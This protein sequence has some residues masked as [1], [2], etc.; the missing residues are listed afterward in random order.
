[1]NGNIGARA[2]ARC[3]PCVSSR[4]AASRSQSAR[5]AAQAIV[6]ASGWL[7]RV[8]GSEETE[9]V[10]GWKE[11]GRQRFKDSLLEVLKTR[12]SSNDACRR[13]VSAKHKRDG[14]S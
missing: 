3:D 11:E 10:G 14:K 12:A 6:P 7:E 5:S 2:T 8:R 4:P 9:A 1:M 13:N